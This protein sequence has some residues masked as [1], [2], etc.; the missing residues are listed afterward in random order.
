[1]TEPPKPPPRPRGRPRAEEPGTS[2]ST[3]MPVSE[4]QRLNALANR[5]RQ[6]LSLTIRQMV[7]V[8]TVK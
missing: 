1:M 3:W 6:S 5:Q 8:F 7:Q 2:V 4:F